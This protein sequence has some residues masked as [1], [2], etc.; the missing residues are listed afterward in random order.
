MKQQLLLT[1]LL[2]AATTAFG[3]VGIG[4][5]DP[6][7]ILDIPASDAANPTNTDGLLIPRLVKLPVT[8][9]TDDQHGMLIYLAANSGSFTPGF[10]YWDKD[11][12]TA[13]EWAPFSNKGWKINGNN[14]ATR[15]THFIGT[16]NSEEVDFRVNNKHIARITEKGQFELESDEKSIFIGFEAG[17]NYSPASS[18]AEQNTVMGFSAFKASTSGRDNVAIGAFSMRSNTTGNF[19]TSIGDE[20]MQ[21]STTGDQNSAFGNDA[22]RFSTTGDR[23]T[24]VGHSALRNNGNGDNN[25]AVGMDALSANSADNNTAVGYEAGETVTNGDSNT[26]I[27]YRSDA[28][29]SS[30]DDAVAVGAESIAGA[31]RTVAVGFQAEANGTA[32]IAIGDKAETSGD[33]AIAIGDGAEAGASNS[34]AIGDGSDADHT[35]A[36]VLGN[37][38][39]STKA[40]QLRYGNIS[41]IDQGYASVVNASDGRFKYQV[42]D[43]KSAVG[44]LNFIMELRPVTYKFDIEKYNSFHDIRSNATNTDKLESGF[45]A[46]EIEEAMNITGYDFSGLVVPA[47]KNTDNYKVSYATFVVP[48]VKAVQEQQVQ[49]NALQNRVSE[50]KNVQNEVA[51]LKAKLEALIKASK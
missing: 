15:G 29:S 2:I 37:G 28:D 8:D 45:I 42:E 36:V 50:L 49:I 47:D 1:F 51:E 6:K 4:T 20:T 31:D 12:G 18:S 27:G 38:A 41:E 11:L 33:S 9:P 25:T 17:E 5:T 24:G 22:L 26:F 32:A 13:G 48:L 40:N 19:N 30:I 3:Q 7:S 16:T 35:D 44:G 14:D 23:N 39:N 21:N 10:H 46:Q 43:G 34:I